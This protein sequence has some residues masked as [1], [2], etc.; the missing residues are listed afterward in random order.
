[1]E[2]WQNISNGLFSAETPSI[3][4]LSGIVDTLVQTYGTE[5]VE[6][7]SFD[8]VFVWSNKEYN[9]HDDPLSWATFVTDW[10]TGFEWDVK[11][12]WNWGLGGIYLPDTD[13]YAGQFNPN[14]QLYSYFHT[15]FTMNFE[16]FYFNI[17][18]NITPFDIRPL[19]ID[20]HHNGAL[21]S[22]CLGISA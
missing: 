12:T 5:P 2:Q 11:G 15:W 16:W 3:A 18:F 20:F 21:L 17:D 10:E 14:I 13:I 19:D 9:E 1:M 22:G 6:L 8:N 7:L 4:S